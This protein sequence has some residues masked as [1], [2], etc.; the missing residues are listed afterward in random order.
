MFLSSARAG[1][2]IP[3]RSLTQRVR[4]V[5]RRAVFHG[6]ELATPGYSEIRHTTAFYPRDVIN[7]YNASNSSYQIHWRQGSTNTSTERD[8]VNNSQQ[9]M[10]PYRD[11]TGNWGFVLNKLNGSLTNTFDFY[12]LPNLPKE[13]RPIYIRLADYL[14]QEITIARYGRRTNNAR[15]GVVIIFYR[16][17]T[18]PNDIFYFHHGNAIP[19]NLINRQRNIALV[20]AN[21]TKLSFPS[22]FIFDDCFL[23]SLSNGQGV[24]QQSYFGYALNDFAGNQTYP[25]TCNTVVYSFPI[26]ENLLDANGRIDPDIYVAIVPYVRFDHTPLEAAPMVSVCVKCRGMS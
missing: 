20:G 12:A 24:L 11:N 4:G 9:V 16:P 22:R 25:S 17:S 7:L 8:L 1:Q 26:R 10:A 23:F 18:N 15:A 19:A 6:A 2:P 3:V 21:P 13:M 5:V 14:P